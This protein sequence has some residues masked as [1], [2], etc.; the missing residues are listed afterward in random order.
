MDPAT[1][2]TATL[3]ILTP[4]ARDA[5]KDL[6]KTVGEI[7][8]EKAKDLFAYLKEKL[9]NDPVAATDMSRFESNP[10]DFEPGLKATI[11]KKAQDNP[12]FAA[13]LERRID[14]VGP[15]ITVFQDIKNGKKLVGLEA[16]EMRS[17]RLVVSQKAEKVDDVIGPRITKIGN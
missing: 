16:D 3:A 5:A 1:L 10:V 13:E 9:T 7:G 11:T 17:G 2:A 4:F 14:E 8:Y 15:A 6:A 12:E